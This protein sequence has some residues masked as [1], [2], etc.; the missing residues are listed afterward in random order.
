M[1]LPVDSGPVDI[2]HRDWLF[3]ISGRELET[4]HAAGILAFLRR[5]K[6][7]GAVL[8]AI[9]S[10]AA[11]LARAGLLDGAECALHPSFHPLVRE[12]FPEVRLTSKTFVVG[13]ATASC[14]GGIATADLFLSIIGSDHGHEL[15]DAV[16]GQMVYQFHHLANARS[17]L[18]VLSRVNLHNRH[19]LKSVRMMEVKLDD[20]VSIAQIAH[21]TGTSARQ[22][23][24]LFKRD[25]GMSPGEYYRQIRMEY[26]RSLLLHTDMRVI[27]AAAAVGVTTHTQVVRMYRSVFDCTPTQELRARKVKRNAASCDLGRVD[28]LTQVSV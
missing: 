8:G 14:A 13:T 3:L 4:R 1:V 20:P 24:R 25:L 2:R 7:R 10:G 16:S 11:L 19:L 18:P 22:L 6:S 28:E 26:A 21:A 5:Q 12:R 27:D 9:D 17:R 15:A 23:A